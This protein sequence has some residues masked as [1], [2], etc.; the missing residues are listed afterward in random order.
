M[1]SI[2]LIPFNHSPATVLNP[3]AS[4]VVPSGKYSLV[5]I[6]KTS[7]AVI[8]GVS[9]PAMDGVGVWLKAGNSLTFS[10]AVHVCEYNIIT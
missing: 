5:T 9:M 6:F 1:S 10:G 8:N 4:Y 2:M 7:S 3:V